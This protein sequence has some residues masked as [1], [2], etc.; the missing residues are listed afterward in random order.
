M[1]SVVR[2]LV[3][4]I[5]GFMAMMVL[6]IAVTLLA[7]K[8]YGLHSGHP[9]PGYLVYNVVA[10]LVAATFGGFVTGSIAHERRVRHGII[11]GLVMM[12]MG[13]LSYMHYRG[14]QPA[15]YQAMLV[16]VPPLFAVAGAKLAERRAARGTRFG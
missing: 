7:V 4:V 9:T 3:A 6:V 2:S 15:W 12:V 5:V 8:A 11:L 16:V 10:S 14:P 13:A 1:P